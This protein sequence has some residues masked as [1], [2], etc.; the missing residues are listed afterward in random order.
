MTPP[1]TPTPEDLLEKLRPFDLMSEESA[2]QEIQEIAKSLRGDIEAY[3]RVDRA[4]LARDLLSTKKSAERILANLADLDVRIALHRTANPDELVVLTI[5]NDNS[6]P[7]RARNTVARFVESGGF[8]VPVLLDNGSVARAY[9]VHSVP[10]YVLVAPDGKVALM[11]EGRI[12][13]EQLD[14]HI[15]EVVSTL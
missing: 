10:L 5:N 2:R 11:H 9:D 14:Q 6:S 3:R 1:P 15:A 13:R 12:S 4:K 8:E 7:E